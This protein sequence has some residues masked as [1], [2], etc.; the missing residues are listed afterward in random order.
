MK[1]KYTEIQETDRSFY[2]SIK[3]RFLDTFGIDGYDPIT[4]IITYTE[5]EI[6]IYDGSQSIEWSLFLS[7]I[8]LPSRPSIRSKSGDYFQLFKNFIGGFDISNEVSF[9]KKF[10]QVIGIIIPVKLTIIPLLKILNWPLKL[11]INMAK[12]IVEILNIIFEKFI[13]IGWMFVSFLLLLISSDAYRFSKSGYFLASLLGVLLL[14]VSLLSVLAVSIGCIALM[15]S[16]GFIRNISLFFLSPVSY[17]RNGFNIPNLILSLFNYESQFI[18][19]LLGFVIVLFMI[20]LFACGWAIALPVLMSVLVTYIPTLFTVIS[21]I[22]HLP[23]LFPILAAINGVLTTMSACVLSTSIG[24]FITHMVLSISVILSV[25]VSAASLA[26][27]VSLAMFVAPMGV[28]LS[29]ITDNL[30]DCWAAWRQ[31]GPITCMS[32]YFINSDRNIVSNSCVLSLSP[33]A[34]NSDNRVTNVVVSS[35]TK[36]QVDANNRTLEYSFKLAEQ[37]D[38]KGDFK[39]LSVDRETFVHKNFLANEDGASIPK[40]K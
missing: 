38:R 12:L 15:V 40:L 28:F 18:S 34:S 7:I 23:L 5:G 4:K 35:V 21:S 9:E 25:Q 17:I 14:I 16:M 13:L 1:F 10:L 19:N 29:W 36:T 3:D 2:G 6:I 8:G 20:G 32:T 11:T 26:F 37:T 33:I 27:G 39:L 24:I 30:S 22:A 31:S